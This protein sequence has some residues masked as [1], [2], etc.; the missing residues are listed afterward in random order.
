MDLTQVGT[1]V[2]QVGFPIALA[3]LLLW[4]F[5]GVLKEMKEALVEITTLL[6]ILC[7]DYVDSAGKHKDQ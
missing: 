5:D 7:R 4:R 6:R 1:V 3:L 2:S